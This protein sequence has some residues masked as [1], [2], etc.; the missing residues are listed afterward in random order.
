M[1]LVRFQLGGQVAYGRLDGKMIQPSRCVVPFGI[2]CSMISAFASC[3]LSFTF[4][5]V[6]SITFRSEGSAA[7]AGITCSRTTVFSL[8]RIISTTFVNS[9]D[10]DIKGL[11]VALQVDFDT[12]AAALSGFDT[13]FR[14]Q[15]LVLAFPCADDFLGGLL[16]VHDVLFLNRR[17]VGRAVL[18]LDGQIEVPGKLHVFEDVLPLA[19]EIAVIEF[20]VTSEGVGAGTAGDQQFDRLGVNLNRTH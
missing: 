4:C 15:N 19:A 3:S 2:L 10:A 1:R 8:P 6:I 9:Q 7:V 5:R 12:L 18:V 13:G 17:G 14:D 11:E 16:L 20:Q